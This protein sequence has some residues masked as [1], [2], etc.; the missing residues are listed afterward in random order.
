V[1]KNQTLWGGY[2]VQQGEWGE[3]GG[4]SGASDYKNPE[5]ARRGWE[6][7]PYEKSTRARKKNSRNRSE[8]NTTQVGGT[9]TRG[10]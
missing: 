3:K 1:K 9:R 8:N 6:Q 4:K 10:G 7:G 2:V 5:T